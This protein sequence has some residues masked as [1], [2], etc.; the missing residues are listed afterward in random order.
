VRS[1]NADQKKGR[2]SAPLV[3]KEMNHLVPMGSNFSEP[4]V[5]YKGGRRKLRLGYAAGS[6]TKLVKMQYLVSNDPTDSFRRQLL[7]MDQEQREANLADVQLTGMLFFPGLLITN[8]SSI[9]LTALKSSLSIIGMLR[10]LSCV[11][12]N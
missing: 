1:K 4:K 3:C 11:G 9:L 8:L 10:F 6:A 7:S 5:G 12:L 2:S